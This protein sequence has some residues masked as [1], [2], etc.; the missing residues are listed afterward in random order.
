[1]RV[2]KIQKEGK[3]CMLQQLRA[4]W[5]RGVEGNSAQRRD[6]DAHQ[7]DRGWDGPRGNRQGPFSLHP[8]EARGHFPGL[9]PDRNRSYLSF[10]SRGG[11]Q[12][13]GSNW[14]NL[15]LEAKEEN[16]W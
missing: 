15:E 3:V 13:V 7:W 1:M 6:T 2:L 11:K 9:A 14:I 10:E 4:A 8:N 12:R 16:G 5:E